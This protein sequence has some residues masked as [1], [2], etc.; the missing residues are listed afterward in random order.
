MFYWRPQPQPGIEIF[1]STT[2]ATHAF[3]SKPIYIR[4]P[5]FPQLCQIIRLPFLV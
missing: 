1:D 4:Y 2:K 3:G 5:F